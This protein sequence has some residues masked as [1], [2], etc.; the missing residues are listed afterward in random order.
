VNAATTV[1]PAQAGGEEVDGDGGFR[2]GAVIGGR[3]VLRRLLGRG[4]AACVFA[5]EHTLV[6]RNVALKL[7][8]PD[9]DQREVLS[10]RL[11]REMEALARVRHPAIV[12]VIDGGESEGFPFLA[13]Q[14]LEGRTLA[15]L[16]ASRGKLA[17]DEVI[18]VGVELAAGLAA[19][20]AAGV[21]HRDVKPSNVLVTRDVVNQVRLFDFGVARL[22]TGPGPEPVQNRKLTHQGAILGTPEYMPQ[23]ALLS[24]PTADHRVDVYALGVTLYECLTGS[25]PF[26]GPLGQVL[27][28]ATTT[29]AAPLH[30][31]RP[32]VPRA[33]AE[34]VHKALWRD[35]AGRFATMS[36]FALA[37]A[38]CTTT[39]LKLVDVL[40][41]AGRVRVASPAP[42]VRS[43]VVMPPLAPSARAAAM[44]AA[45]P[46]V[47]ITNA[48]ARPA[49]SGPPPLTSG[50]V[51]SAAPQGPP[52]EV[53][54]RRTTA[55]AP[56]VT[57]ASLKRERRSSFDA[58]IEDIS[59][60]GVLLVASEACDQGEVVHL[61][62]SLPL[63]SKVV[64]AEAKVRWTRDARGTRATGLEFVALPE[65]ARAEVK[66]YVALMSGK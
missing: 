23:E 9:P 17:H 58:R 12:D 32:D 18:K 31:V 5:A 24:Q 54:A 39:N 56:Y 61:R 43:D 41:G 2:V 63:T 35:P 22:S 66:Q 45:S 29:D 50:S 7:P 26:D 14:L 16:V 4:G 30:T 52:P 27:L 42:V 53:V 55:R 11:R 33:L 51:V 40:Q 62:F 13:M 1:D 47:Q 15:G 34:V 48:P 3:Y 44:A 38:A 49:G 8:H 21:I 57:L 25:V 60:G 28:K 10:A 19:V 6:R 64:V 37:L 59:E 36:D 20:H 46:P 65:A